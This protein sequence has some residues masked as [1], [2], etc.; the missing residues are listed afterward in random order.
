MIVIPTSDSRID[1][2]CRIETMSLP[3]SEPT[4]RGLQIPDSQ[5]N[6]QLYSTVLVSASLSERR[7]DG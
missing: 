6:H 7:I 5:K 3:P 2:R 1:E 4:S